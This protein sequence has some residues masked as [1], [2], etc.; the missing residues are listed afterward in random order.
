[1]FLRKNF[2]STICT[3]FF[4]LCL[5]IIPSISFASQGSTPTGEISSNKWSYVIA[6]YGLSWA[7]LLGYLFSLYKRGLR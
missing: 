2:P 7:A 1:M 4:V 3:V 5:V 6:A